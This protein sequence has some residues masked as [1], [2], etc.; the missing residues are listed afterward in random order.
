MSTQTLRN[1]ANQWIFHAQRLPGI[2]EADEAAIRIGVPS[3]ALAILIGAGHLKPLGKP[4]DKSSKK[5]SADYVENLVHDQKWLDKAVQIIANHWATQNR[6]KKIV[7][8]A[9]TSKAA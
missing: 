8:I 1:P 3:H 7:A 6:K 2:L 5:F 4:S 9:E